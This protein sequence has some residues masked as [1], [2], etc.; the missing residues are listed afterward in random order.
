VLGHAFLGPVV[1][2]WVSLAA[3]R[4]SRFAK[5]YEKWVDFNQKYA[6]VRPVILESTDPMPKAVAM[7]VAMVVAMDGKRDRL[8]RHFSEKPAA[9]AA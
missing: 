7:A 3:T 2:T 8:A 6:E 4:P 5:A 1:E 9:E